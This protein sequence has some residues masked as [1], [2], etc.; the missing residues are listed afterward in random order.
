[1]LL[2]QPVLDVHLDLRRQGAAGRGPL[3]GGLSFGRLGARVRVSV[4]V[5]PH[6]LGAILK[7]RCSGVVGRSGY[8]RHGAWA[9]GGLAVWLLLNGCGGWMGGV[10]YSLS[11]CGWPTSDQTFHTHTSLY[12][13]PTF[14][15]NRDIIVTKASLNTSGL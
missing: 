13:F 14:T 15:S 9:C 7:L 8:G 1:M 3:L 11:R 2:L 6:L 12:R 5:H 10:A 4:L